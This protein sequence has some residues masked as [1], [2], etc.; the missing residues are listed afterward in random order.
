M[1]SCDIHSASPIS[2]V[3]HLLNY[4]WD[5]LQPGS[6]VYVCSDAMGEFLQVFEGIP[7]PIILVTG[8]SDLDVPTQIFA[9]YEEFFT[10]IENPKI[11]HWFSQNVVLSHPK[12]SQI[13]IGLYYHIVPVGDSA[14]EQPKISPPD[15]EKVLKT[16]IQDSLSLSKRKVK[17]YSNFHF[18]MTTK[19]GED[20]IR[21]KRLISP[22]LIDYEPRRV[23]RETTWKNQSKYA[24]VVSPHGNG[25]DCHRTWEA[26]S[27]GCIP[28]VKTSPLDSLYEGLPV[29]IVKDWSDVTEENLRKVLNEFS[30]RKFDLNRLTLKYWMGKINSKKIF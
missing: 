12:L 11:I 30:Q 27:L 10:F 3:S 4:N 14:W 18:L 16:I 29:Y 20:R 7:H 1:K 23:D 15:Q 24:F 6:T 21:A 13:P 17:A 9:S 22:D 26:L 25:L 19:Y 5:N 8:D 2:T 28:I